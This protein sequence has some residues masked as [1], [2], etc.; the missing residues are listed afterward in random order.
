MQRWLDADDI[1]QSRI[2]RREL[3]VPGNQTSVYINGLESNTKYTFNI[4]ARYDRNWGPVYTIDVE[5]SD[6]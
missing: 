3:S 1:R 2:G 4:S 6:G 5:T